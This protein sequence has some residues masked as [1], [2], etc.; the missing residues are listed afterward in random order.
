MPRRKRIRK[1]SLD[2]GLPPEGRP[3]LEQAVDDLL[4]RLDPAGFFLPA[5]SRPKIHRPGLTA[6]NRALAGKQLLT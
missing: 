5:H 1:I 4:Q 6:Q 2:I 3:A